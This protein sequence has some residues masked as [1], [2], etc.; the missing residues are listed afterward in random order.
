[1]TCTQITVI[2]H[3]I[4]VENSVKYMLCCYTDI[5]ET[6]FNWLPTLYS[7][8]HGTGHHFYVYNSILVTHYFSDKF[9]NIYRIQNADLSTLTCRLG[10]HQGVVEVPQTPCVAAA[11][12]TGAPSSGHRHP[13]ARP[14]TEGHRTSY[15]IL[16]MEAN[17][18]S[19]TRCLVTSVTQSE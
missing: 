4:C 6:T 13:D 2:C 11:Q 9:Q 10:R 12:W 3:M 15:N 8:L 19:H 5:Q 7:I 1:M 16:L 14:C 17:T 18:T